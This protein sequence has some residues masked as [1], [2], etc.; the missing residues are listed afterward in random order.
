M[1]PGGGNADAAEQGNS[2]RSME[3]L[4]D[5]MDQGVTHYK[6]HGMVRAC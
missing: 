4:T 1:C 3:L 2:K 5:S 6:H